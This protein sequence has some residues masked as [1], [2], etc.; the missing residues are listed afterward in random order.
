MGG[1]PNT[2]MSKLMQLMSCIY[3]VM[4]VVEFLQ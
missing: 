3:S 2:N 1:P 4:L